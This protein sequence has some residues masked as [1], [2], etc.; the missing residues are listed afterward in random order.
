MT[1]GVLLVDKHGI[2]RD[3][4][5]ARASGCSAYITKPFDT[6]TFAADVARLLGA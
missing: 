2:V 1:I 3:D 6:R 5:K 4:R